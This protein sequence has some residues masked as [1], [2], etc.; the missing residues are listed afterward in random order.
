[1]VR[2]ATVNKKGTLDEG[3]N[4]LIIFRFSR[5]LRGEPCEWDGVR[6]KDLRRLVVSYARGPKLEDVVRFVI[7]YQESVFFI[8]GEGQWG[9][10]MGIRLNFG[11]CFI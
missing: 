4:Y 11:F 6:S 8:G 5:G 1:M 3:K 7:R 2:A 9:Q 10:Q